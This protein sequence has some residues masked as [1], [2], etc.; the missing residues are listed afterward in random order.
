MAKNVT[1][2]TNRVLSIAWRMNPT[3]PA[4]LAHGM[5]ENLQVIVTL[6]CATALDGNGEKHGRLLQVIHEWCRQESEVDI[7]NRMID[8]KGGN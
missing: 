6:F 7:L 2:F 4:A 1:K 5:S 8:P 3:M